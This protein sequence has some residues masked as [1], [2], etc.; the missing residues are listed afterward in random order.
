MSATI[1]TLTGTCGCGKTVMREQAEGFGADLLNGLPFVCPECSAEREAAWEREDAARQQRED[2][3][4]L[5]MKLQSLPVALRDAR[6]ADLDTD[7]RTAAL[8]AAQRW[9]GGEL[10]GLVLLGSIGVGKTT[11]AA[12]AVR[13]YMV[14]NLRRPSP[15]WI[16]TVQA[17]NDLSRDFNDRRRVQ[18]MN[19]LDGQHAALVLDDIDKAKPNASAA[20]HVFGAIDACLTHERPLIVTTNLMPSQLA[21]YW[22]KPHGQTIASRLAGYCELHKITGRDRRVNR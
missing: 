11:I 6:L 12:A 14:N 7:G 2:Q 22:P 1:A 3:D 4:W 19:A 18:T 8:D 20:A 21:A 10:K 17:L 15:R 13:A 16:N 9:S 5:G